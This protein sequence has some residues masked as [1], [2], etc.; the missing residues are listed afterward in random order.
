MDLQAVWK[1][2]INKELG[3][4]FVGVVVRHGSERASQDRMYCI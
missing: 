2:S 3:G 1:Y 4:I